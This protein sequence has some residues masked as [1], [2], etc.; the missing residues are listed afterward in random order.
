MAGHRT[1]GTRAIHLTT[2]AWH[3]CGR[4]SMTA[5]NR[6]SP[7]HPAP[8]AYHCYDRHPPGAGLTPVICPMPARTCWPARTNW[9]AAA[10]A[11]RFSWTSRTNRRCATCPAMRP[12]VGEPGHRGEQ[13]RHF[14]KHEDA[15]ARWRRCRWTNGAGCWR[16]ISP[17]RSWSR[18]LAYAGAHRRRLGSRVIMI[19]SQAA[20]DAPDARAPIIRR[21]SP[22]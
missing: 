7:G 17:A 3:T 4:L 6:S 13:C 1:A 10:C 12:V 15:S 20:R 2:A 16:S 9:P 18:R 22:A 11:R 5:A 21:P 14:P 19:T 8:R